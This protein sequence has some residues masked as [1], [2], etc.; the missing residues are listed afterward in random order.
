[1]RGAGPRWNVINCLTLHRR[2]DLLVEEEITADLQTP[3]WV[4]ERKVASLAA[5][6]G[7]KFPRLQPGIPPCSTRNKMNASMTP[8][9][10]PYVSPVDSPFI[11]SWRQ[12]VD[13]VKGDYARHQRNWTR[14]GFQA[15]VVYRFGIWRYS[16]K[17]PFVRK[18]MTGLYKLLN[19]FVRNVY[20]IEIT[21][22][23][24]IGRRL[25]IAHQHGITVHSHAVI[26]DDCLIRQGVSIGRAANHGGGKKTL[27]PRLGTGSKL[28]QTRSSLVASR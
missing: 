10:T 24:V 7:A 11:C 28:E 8:K 1:M 9:R 17:N 23:A 19:I 4:G 14:P 25:R 6:Q 22:T 5:L 27:L 2:L 12:F 21:G 13:Y 20:G 3:F 18:P 15:M 26:G 16:F